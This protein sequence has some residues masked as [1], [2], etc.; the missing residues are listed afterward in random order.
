[1]VKIAIL[2]RGW[3]FVGEY[4][5]EGS[6]CRL[7]NAFC[8]RT[9]GTEKGLGQIALGG[10][11]GDTELDYAGVVRFHELTTVALIDCVPEKWADTLEKKEWACVYK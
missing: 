1:M 9:W 10:P 2:Q 5:Q 11:T 6:A 8:I 7:E 4:I 3:I